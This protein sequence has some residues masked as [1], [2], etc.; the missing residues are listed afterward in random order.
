MISQK[1]RF[2]ENNNSG[3]YYFRKIQVPENTI[4]GNTISGNYYVPEILFPENTISGKYDFRKILFPENTIA[5]KYDFPEHTISRNILF[6]DKYLGARAPGPGGLGGWKP[7]R[8]ALTLIAERRVLCSLTYVG[9]CQPLWVSER[10]S[11]I[12]PVTSYNL[13]I[14][15][16][17][18]CSL[19][20]TLC[21]KTLSLTAL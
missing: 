5:G 21:G 3:K 1:I 7:P 12:P 18:R 4:S 19:M 9:L 2:P 10:Q 20:S 14:G 13:C 17:S 8:K 15:G 11:L 6:P 16:V